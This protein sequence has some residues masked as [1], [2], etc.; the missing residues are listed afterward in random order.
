MRR[1]EPRIPTAPR[2]RRNR[3]DCFT[4]SGTRFRLLPRPE[5]MA[6][7]ALLSTLLMTTTP[8]PPSTWEPGVAMVAV[9]GDLA[10]ALPLHLE[11]HAPSTLWGILENPLDVKVYRFDLQVTGRMTA[12]LNAQ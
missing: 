1:S 5:A 8:S 4:P 6:A 12:T 3:R 10:D 2:R 9:P 7:R 11:T